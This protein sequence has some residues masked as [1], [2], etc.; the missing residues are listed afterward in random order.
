VS[1]RTTDSLDFVFVHQYLVSSKLPRW[2]FTAMRTPTA[3]RAKKLRQLE[4]KYDEEIH[5]PH[6]DDPLPTHVEIVRQFLLDFK[7][8]ERFAEGQFVGLPDS[9]E[10]DLRYQRKDFFRELE[11]EE[12]DLY[13]RWSLQPAGDVWVSKGRDELAAHFYEALEVA[14]DRDTKTAEQAREFRNAEKE[15]RGY[16]E[17]DWNDVFRES[18]FRRFPSMKFDYEYG[19][20]VVHS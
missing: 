5:D 2:Q 15:N 9:R 7:S 13:Q 1:L 8:F 18:I 12:K 6:T 17:E 20:S 11:P 19:L 10:R 3:T 16:K 4:I 14:A